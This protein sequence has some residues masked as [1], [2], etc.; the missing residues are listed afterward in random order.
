M[1]KGLFIF[2]L[3]IPLVLFGQ[4]YWDWWNELHDYPNAAGPNRRRYINLSPG[5]MGPNALPVVRLFDAKYEDQLWLDTQWQF[6]EGNGDQTN[7]AFLRLNIPVAKDIVNL[8]LFNVPYE[9]WETTPETRD[10]R[11]AMNIA[12]QGEN[13]GDLFFGFNIMVLKE[14]KYFV[15]AMINVEVK[16]TTGWQIENARFTDHGMYTYGGHFSKT[17]IDSEKQSLLLKSM[18]GFVTWQTNQNRL[19]GGSNQ[20]QNDALLYG[21]GVEWKPGKWLVSSDLSGYSGYIGNRDNP[22]FWRSQIQYN[23]SRLAFRT[24]MNVGL[25]WWDWNTVSFGLRYHFTKKK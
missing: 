12:A 24:E 25:R 6:H 7:N 14:E 9:S 8:Y 3:N 11:R 10:E 20:L 4:D 19:P 16:T 17:I 23:L 1:R 22:S 21:F 13:S 18:L 15:N 2:L 5:Y